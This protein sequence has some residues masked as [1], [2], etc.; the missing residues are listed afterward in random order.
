VTV[1][2]DDLLARRAQEL[3]GGYGADRMTVGGVLRRRI[4]GHVSILVLTRLA[5]DEYGGLEELPSGGVEQGETLGEALA[6]EVWE[7]TG[8]GI[9]AA[10]P[11][12]FDFTYPSRRGRTVQLNFLVEAA[13][14]VPVRVN[15]AEH[16]SFRWL[17]LAALPDSGLSSN[18]R[19]GLSLVLA[20]IADL[21]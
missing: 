4:R 16:Q 18:V 5:G 13:D 17:P 1:S 21:P 12:L 20:A 9:H 3:L 15:A 10:G 14:D 19:Q 7:E 11:F 6:R 2:P 8:L